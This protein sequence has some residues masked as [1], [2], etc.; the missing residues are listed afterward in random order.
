MTEPLMT[1]QEFITKLNSDP[2][3]R[4][5][6]DLGNLE[7]DLRYNNADGNTEGA[8]FGEMNQLKDLESTARKNAIEKL[9]LSKDE[10]NQIDDFKKYGGSLNEHLRDAAAA[11]DAAVKPAE[12]AL[13]KAISEYNKLQEDPKYAPVTGSIFVG[14]PTAQLDGTALE[15]LEVKYDAA[16]ESAARAALQT[17]ISEEE[18]MLESGQLPSQPVQRGVRAPVTRGF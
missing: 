16:V 13:S 2:Q 4:R 8:A 10:V 11:I 3:T 5:E 1:G 15:A 6:W 9:G 17:G 7:R 14:S 18:Q 12:D